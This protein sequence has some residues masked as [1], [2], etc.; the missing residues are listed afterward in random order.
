MSKNIIVTQQVK[1]AFPIG[2][3][4]LFWALKGINI[5]VPQNTLT[6]LKGRSGSG[7]TTLLNILSALDVA[8]EGKV[9]FQG[10]EINEIEENKREEIRR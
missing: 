6:I 3:E 9:F 8:T 1:R 4:E 10:Q 5:E 7:K 2:K